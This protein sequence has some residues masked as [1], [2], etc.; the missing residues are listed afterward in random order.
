M[1]DIQLVMN[2]HLQ[3]MTTAVIDLFVL[4]STYANSFHRHAFYICTT[5]I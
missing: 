2:F 1:Q 4:L 5:T 3:I